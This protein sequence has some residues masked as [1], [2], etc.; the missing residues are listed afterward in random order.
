LRFH[1]LQLLNRRVKEFVINIGHPKHGS[2]APP[3]RTQ[4]CRE[5]TEGAPGTGSEGSNFTIVPQN[6]ADAR[7]ERFFVPRY[8]RV[9]EYGAR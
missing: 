4:I 1:F 6:Q 5:R 9:T 8:A 7:Y 3:N 2:A